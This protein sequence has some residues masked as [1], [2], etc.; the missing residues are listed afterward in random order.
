MSPYSACP[1]LLPQPL[2]TVSVPLDSID[3]DIPSLAPE[4]LTGPSLMEFT[5]ALETCIDTADCDVQLDAGLFTQFPK[6]WIWFWTIWL[7][8]YMDPTLFSDLSLGIVRH[9][10][11]IIYGKMLQRL[12]SLGYQGL[13]LSVREVEIYFVWCTL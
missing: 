11:V 13:E 8:S 4:P 6:P 1:F 9:Y 2:N 3:T 10:E 12:S 7:Y 5:R